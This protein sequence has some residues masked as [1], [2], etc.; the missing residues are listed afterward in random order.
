MDDWS[1][2]QE[3]IIFKGRCS[4]N[5]LIKNKSLSGQCRS[6]DGFQINHFICDQWPHSSAYF[7]FNQFRTMSEIGFKLLCTA[8]TLSHLK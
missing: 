7:G 1:V 3:M 5:L 8:L 2:A 6:L 4:K